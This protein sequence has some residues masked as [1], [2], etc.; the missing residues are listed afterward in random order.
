MSEKPSPNNE[1]KKKPDGLS[2][3]VAK[4]LD[5]LAITAWLP[6]ALLIGVMALF[7]ELSRHPSDGLDIADAV[8]SLATLPWGTIII[9]IFGLVLTTMVTQAFAFGAIR[10][11]EGYW[12]SSKFGSWATGKRVTR[13]SE[14]SKGLDDRVKALE[15]TAFLAAKPSL[16]GTLPREQLDLIEERVLRVPAAQRMVATPEVR[17]AATAVKWRAKAAPE[18]VAVLERTY[19]RL[20]DYPTQPHRLLPTRMGNI[21]RA[22]EDQLGLQGKSLEGFLMRNYV[23]IPPR[24]LLQHDQW[25][26][27]LEMYAI[28][29]C[30][31]AV[32]AL[33]SIPLLRLNLPYAIGSVIGFVSMALLG[34]LFYRAAVASARGYG[35]VL[36]SMNSYVQGS[37]SSESGGSGSQVIQQAPGGAT[38]PEP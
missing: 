7:V 11:L 25:R 13:H 35:A 15:Y 19:S 2:S 26:D 37:H 1:E 23:A 5:Q 32:L 27:R 34:W 21:I 8:Q 14:L 10:T 18:T 31:S 22:S 9:L 30:V 36:A 17:R 4:V 16:I 28:L 12:G 29:I 33:A 20:A 24:L 6:A 38:H 3:F